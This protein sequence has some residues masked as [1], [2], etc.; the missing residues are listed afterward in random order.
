MRE[1]GIL[2]IAT[3][4]LAPVAA[5]DETRADCERGQQWFGYQSTDAIRAEYARRG[6]P[7]GLAVCEGEHWDGQDG[8]DPA[9]P[10]A[11]ED[12][13]CQGMD[14]N[15]GPADGPPL[16]ATARA[17][18]GEREAYASANVL[19]VGRVALYAGTCATGEDGLE[20]NSTCAGSRQARLAAYHRDNAPMNAVCVSLSAIGLLRSYCSEADA[21]H[22]EYVCVSNGMCGRGVGRDNTAVTVE[23]VLP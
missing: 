4:L 16:A 14:P 9:R 3:A 2:V 8:V 12:A 6:S 13:A 21:T 1:I 7:G 19:L 10:C 18:R 23:S 15:E 11:P 5:A 20:G 17:S 22:A